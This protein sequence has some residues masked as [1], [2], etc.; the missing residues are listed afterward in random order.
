MKPTVPAVVRINRFLSMCGVASRRKADEMVRAG[1]VRVNGI[2]LTDCGVRVRPERDVVTV[3]GERARPGR[4][5]LYIVLNKPRDTITTLSD[6]RNRT[7]VLSHL[8]LRRRVFPVGRLDRNTTGVLL[9]TDDGEFAHRLMHPRYRVPKAYRVTCTR[10][11]ALHDVERLRKGVLLEEGRTSPAEVHPLG[12]TGGK[13]LGIVVHEGRNRQVRRMLEVLGYEV[14][15][16]E[17]VAYGPVTRR[18]L[19]RGA[20]RSLTRAELRTLRRLVGLEEE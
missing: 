3:N 13:E 11:V 4:E 1:K 15:K 20:S 8:R 12:G 9:L 6:E 10:A 14:E 5:H 16:L 2:A 7:T 17:R 18:G 19:A